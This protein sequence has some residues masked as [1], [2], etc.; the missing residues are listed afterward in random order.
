[1][2]SFR[3]C[4]LE[5]FQITMNGYHSL[6]V[7]QKPTKNYHTVPFCGNLYITRWCTFPDAIASALDIQ[8][9]VVQ[10][11]TA[12]IL[13][14]FLS[15]ET[16]PIAPSVL[17]PFLNTLSSFL[18]SSFPHKRDLA[19]QCLEALLPRREVRKAVWGIPQIIQ[20]YEGKTASIPTNCLSSLVDIIK[21][22][23]GPQM[24]YQIAFCFWLLTFE[25]EIAQEINKSVLAT[26]PS[27][28]NLL[29]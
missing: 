10:L 8:D 1:M 4:P 22:G 23:P 15:S 6:P 18:I 21:H 11:K 19:V 3:P 14:V 2:R 7:P 13:T 20:G 28:P 17:Q 16:A 12:Q 26:S 5:T 29:A 27:Y 9:D 24:C 25:Q